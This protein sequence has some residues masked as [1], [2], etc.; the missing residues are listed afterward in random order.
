MSMLVAPLGLTT[1]IAAFNGGML[2]HP[3]LSPIEQLTLPASVVA[4]AVKAIERHALDV[5]IYR[6][7]DWFVRAL[8]GAHVDREQK[9]VLFAPTVVSTFDGMDQEIVK[10]VGVGDDL[11][12]VARC[13]RDVRQQ[14]GAHVSAARSQPYY[15]DITHPNAN[16]GAVVRRLSELLAVPTSEIATIGDMPSD[17]LM[18]TPSG[19]GIAMGNASADV[20]RAARRVTGS[21]AEEGFAEAVETYILPTA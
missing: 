21:N 2:V 4:Q 13:E 1:P 17:V 10:I 3:D 7:G 9:T 18:F 19:L 12:V 5:W 16:K 11:D 20:Q 14:L 15:L 6:R 8:T